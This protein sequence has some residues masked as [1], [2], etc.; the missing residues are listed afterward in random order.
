MTTD[1]TA[2]GRPRHVVEAA[3]PHLPSAAAAAAAA[4]DAASDVPHQ[5]WP[6]SLTLSPG[7]SSLTLSPSS[8]SLPYSRPQKEAS[9]FALPFSRI[10]FLHRFFLYFIFVVPLPRAAPAAARVLHVNNQRTYDGGL[11]FWRQIL[12]R[13]IVFSI[14]TCAT[15]PSKPASRF[16]ICFFQ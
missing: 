6:C 11:R 12:S 5:G 15:S 14:S 1:G 9:L 4:A 10:P 13:S 2:A 7:P 3:A 16:I 8:S